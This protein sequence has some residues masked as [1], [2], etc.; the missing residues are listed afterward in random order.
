VNR[1]LGCDLVELLVALLEGFLD[2]SLLAVTESLLKIPHRVLDAILAPV[3]TG[4]SLDVLPD[5][6]LG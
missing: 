4:A 6:L 5:S 1:A 2:G 3:I